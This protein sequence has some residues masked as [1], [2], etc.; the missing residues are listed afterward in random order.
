M[1]QIQIEYK[2][3]WKLTNSVCAKANDK[4]T[5]IDCLKIDNILHYT[6]ENTTN[7]FGH[8][9]SKLKS[10][11]KPIKDCLML[12]LKSVKSIFWSPCNKDKIAKLI[13][14]LPNKTSSGFD[15]ISNFL[16]KKLQPSVINIHKQIF[17]ESIVTGE[18]PSF[19]KHAEIVHLFKG[20]KS[21]FSSNYRPISLLITISKI[22]EKL[23]YSHTYNF[24][25]DNGLIYNSQ[26]G[27]RSN[28]SCEHAIQNLSVKL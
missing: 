13:I 24:L 10:S 19:M 21:Y 8:Y 3:L 14:N 4:R 1:L 5:S 18:L 22:L 16:L 2:K 9:F 12:M 25:N 15:N 27:F 23:V 26:Y 7:E 17:N 28:H 11:N 20:G 6:G